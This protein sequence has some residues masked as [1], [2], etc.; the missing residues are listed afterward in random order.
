MLEAQIRHAARQFAYPPTPDIAGKVRERL[1]RRRQLAPTLMRFAVTAI[2]VL[3]ALG[4]LLAVPQVRATVLEILR[5]G[6]VTIFVGEP[7]PTPMASQPSPTARAT[8][9]GILNSVLDLDG[10]TTFEAAEA[11]L[12][13]SIPLPT[14]PA[15][16]GLPD[17]VFVQDLGMPMV[18]LVWVAPDDPDQVLLSLHVID[19]R[20]S[21][22]KYEP[23]VVVTTR[24]NGQRAL[25]LEAPHMFAYY[26]YDDPDAPLI[27]TVE[28]NVLLWDRGQYTYRLELRGTME[29]AIRIAES[30]EVE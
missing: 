1:N 28:G 20:A 30:L 16:L 12:G 25:W 10:E 8:D 23:Q 6:A 9:D 19:S 24:V 26:G 11:Q 2:L 27:R 3:L 14:Y 22:L 13:Q 15:E 29:E 7:S 18:S 17:R 21:A 5:L 4:G